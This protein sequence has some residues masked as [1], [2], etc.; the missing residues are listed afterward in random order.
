MKFN[1]KF[2]FEICFKLSVFVHFFIIYCL[3]TNWLLWRHKNVYRIFC[4]LAKEKKK[5]TKE[6][7]YRRSYNIIPKT[8]YYEYFII[9]FLQHCKNFRF[10]WTFSFT[11]YIQSR[12]WHYRCEGT[13]EGYVGN[14]HDLL[15]EC[16]MKE[17]ASRKAT[18]IS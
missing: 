16:Q 7:R 2:T 11:I 6:S 13:R 9:F 12:E 5:K 3:S 1:P 17:S 18:A 8:L 14:M 15:C 10:L 4:R